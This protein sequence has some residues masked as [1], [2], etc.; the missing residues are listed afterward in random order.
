MPGGSQ[1]P[2]GSTSGMTMPGGA[3]GSEAQGAVGKWT[4]LLGKSANNANFFAGGSGSEGAGGSTS[5]PP[6]GIGTGGSPMPPG[7][8]PTSGPAGAVPPTGGGTKTKFPTEFIV[9]MIWRE[10]NPTDTP[11]APAVAK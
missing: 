4:G 10:P 1:M 7:T 2:G 6:L 3:S 8:G 5:M 9:Y 11:T